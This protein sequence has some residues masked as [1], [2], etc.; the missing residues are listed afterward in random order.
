MLKN[1]QNATQALANAQATNA[2]S[3]IAQ[4]KTAHALVKNV[5]ANLKNVIVNS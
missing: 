5:V 2:L 3:A 1:V 4:Q